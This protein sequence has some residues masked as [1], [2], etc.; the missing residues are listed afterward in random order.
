[1]FWAAELNFRGALGYPGGGNQ[2]DNQIG[3]V[4]YRFQ[5]QKCTRSAHL[6][7]IWEIPVLGCEV[8]FSVVGVTC[9]FLPSEL[10]IIFIIMPITIAGRIKFIRVDISMPLEKRVLTIFV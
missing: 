9:F 10:P 4:Y 8:G 7:L 2:V 1:M 3:G 5:E 6:E